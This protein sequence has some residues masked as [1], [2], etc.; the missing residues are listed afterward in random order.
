MKAFSSIILSL[1]VA[2]CTYSSSE[3]IANSIIQHYPLD[4][5]RYIALFY[6]D[7]WGCLNCN[8][9][10]K[11][12][13]LGSEGRSLWGENAFFLYPGLRETEWKG[14]DRILSEIGNIDAKS[15][16]DNDLYLAVQSEANIKE[17]DI[18]KPIIALVSTNSS[19]SYYFFIRDP[20]LKVKLQKL[21]K[22]ER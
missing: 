5:S 2:G 21:V 20:D 15:I 6:Y 22:M 11:N 19:E 14:T 17:D 10:L 12:I 3:K 7:P 13:L 18:G 8:H 16:N 9:L 4:S 1:F